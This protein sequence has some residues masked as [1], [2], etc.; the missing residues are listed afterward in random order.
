ME[1][2]VNVLISVV[3]G[4][5]LGIM[6]GITA[7]A[8]VTILSKVANASDV[9][10][11]TNNTCSLEDQV[12]AE[13]I[14]ELETCLVNKMRIRGARKSKIYLVVHSPGGSVYRGIRFIQFAKEIPN[15]ET[16]TL[17]AASMASGIVQALP[18]TRHITEDAFMMFHRASGQFSGQFETGDVETQLRLWKSVVRKMEMVNSNRIGITLNDYKSR[19]VNEWWLYGNENITQKTA[20]KISTVRCSPTLMARKKTKTIQTLFGT[21]KDVRSAC[22]LMN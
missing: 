11:T 21:F 19:I 2:I 16:V 6:L 18:G 15:L 3:K 20:D 1:N 12:D 17:F 7:M 14:Q 10:L 5:L 22:P 13:T 4:F 9:V 8:F